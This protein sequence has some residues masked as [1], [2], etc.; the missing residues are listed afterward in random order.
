[1]VSNHGADDP[2]RAATYDADVVQVPR[3]LQQRA[4]SFLAAGEAAVVSTPRDAATVILLREASSAAPHSPEGRRAAGGAV[5]GDSGRPLEVY[6]LRRAATMA[7]A[8]GMHVFPGG[9]VDPRDADAT[10]SWVGPDAATWAGWLGCVE[11]LALALVCAAVRETFEESGV[12]LAGPD[13]T[14]VVTTSGSAT[15]RSAASF[16][17]EDLEADRLS[18]LD[19]SRSMAQVLAERSLVLRSDLLRPWS[20]WLTPEFEPKRFDT[21]FFVAA[22]PPGQTPRDVSGE[23]DRTLWIEIDEAVRRHDAGDLAMLLPTSAAL[24]DIAALGGLDSVLR[25]P[26]RLHRILPRLVVEGGELSLVVDEP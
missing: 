4:E 16:S 18:L 8:A 24:S 15:T 19:G 5:A 6:L 7:F 13:A 26:R 12:L 23:A 2:H 17:A 1:M 11:Q 21:R 10:I 9:S 22:V 14:S 3:S 20:H 25:A